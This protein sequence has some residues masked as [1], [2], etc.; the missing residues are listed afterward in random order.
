MNGNADPRLNSGKV[1]MRKALLVIDVQNTLTKIGVNTAHMIE[2]INSV[3]AKVRA[4]NDLVIFIR[5]GNDNYPGM[6][7]GQDGWQVDSRLSFVEGDTFVNKTASD[8]FYKSE[9]EPL[10]KERNVNE[11]IIT[12]MQTEFCVDATARSALSKDYLVTLISDGHTTTD[13]DLTAAQVIAHH[14][15]TLASLAHP[16][17][18]IQVISSETFT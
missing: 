8:S 5:H 7:I 15:R 10:L 18:S 17:K 12:G 9:L 4:S 14:N 3:I 16:I 13:S 6:K 1:K 2:S 11:V